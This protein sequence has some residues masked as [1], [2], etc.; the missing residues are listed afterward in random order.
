MRRL[1]W[2]FAGCKYHIV[3]NL[4]SGFIF[5][6]Q[7]IVLLSVYQKCGNHTLT[8]FHLHGDPFSGK[9]GSY[10]PSRSANYWVII[11]RQIL[12]KIGHRG[13]QLQTTIIHIE[14]KLEYSIHKTL[15]YTFVAQVKCCKFYLDQAWWRGKSE[16]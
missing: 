2:A 9:S 8:L 4:M 14:F 12:V 1:V 5:I 10:N 15:W 3:G 6:L 7:S 16:T 11:Y 13:F